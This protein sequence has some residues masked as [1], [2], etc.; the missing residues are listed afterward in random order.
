MPRRKEWRP[1]SVDPDSD[2]YDDISSALE[3]AIE[4]L[5]NMNAAEAWSTPPDDLVDRYG[6]VWIIAEFGGQY[7]VNG[8][9]VLDGEE[10]PREPE[11]YERTREGGDVPAVEGYAYIDTVV[12]VVARK[13]NFREEDVR[14]VAE[15]EGY[16]EEIP[17]GVSG[18]TEVWAPPDPKVLV[19]EIPERERTEVYA[20]EEDIGEKWP[21]HS[22]WLSPVSEA[23]PPTVRKKRKEWRPGAKGVFWSRRA[24]EIAAKRGLDYKAA[25]P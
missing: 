21:E 8:E 19:V 7:A 5:A 25:L 1:F 9:S 14:A 20:D 12:D 4:E 3:S 2:L 13:H 10:I 18:N 23:P 22:G 15:K 24:V 11:G 6:E 17:W 16:E